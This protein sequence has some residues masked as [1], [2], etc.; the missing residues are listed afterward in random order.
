MLLDY[1]RYGFSS[2]YHRFNARAFGFTSAV[3]R[4]LAR[5]R[6]A[7]TRVNYQA[8]WSVFRAWCRRHS[9]SVSRPSIPKIASFLLYLRRSLSLSYSSIASCRSMLSGVFHFVLPELS[10]HFV[11]RDLL[12]SFRLERPLSSS[13]LGF[14][15]GISLVFFPFSEALPLSLCLLA[16]F[17]IFLVRFSSWF[18]WRQLVGWVSFRRSLLR[19]PLPV[20]TS[21]CPIFL[22]FGLSR[23]PKLTL[24]RARPGFV[25][26]RTSWVT[27]RMN[28][29]SVLFML[30]G[31]ISLGLL[32]FPLVLG[33]CSFLLVLLLVLF[34]KM[35]SVS[36]LGMSLRSLILRLA[37][38]FPHS[39]LLRLPPLSLPLLL[40]VVLRCVLMG[41]GVS[42][43]LGLFIVTLLCLLFWRP[44]PGLRFLYLLPSAFLMFSSL[45]LGVS[46]WVRW[47]LRVL[48]FSFWFVILDK[49]SS[50]YFSL[51][52]Q[53]GVSVLGGNTLPFLVCSSV[54][55]LLGC[56]HAPWSLRVVLTPLYGS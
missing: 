37:F 44:L 25:P 9:H 17:G 6:R 13:L 30:F 10:S 12:C 23:S 11:L 1:L 15:L 24:F 50:W 31:C 40:A 39:P 21:S 51:L 8:K 32:L 14:H 4:Q 35:L 55:E 3:A 46:V 28:S 45:L 36:S 52:F 41:F 43:L 19:S 20:R 56:C 47:W 49:L 48:W 16:L 2:F 34:L 29:S 5:C 33:L 27:F 7:S 22:S 53:L 42:R 38:L 26:C 18:L 54:W